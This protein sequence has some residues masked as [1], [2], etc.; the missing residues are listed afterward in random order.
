VTLKRGENIKYK[1]FAFSEHGILMLSSVLGSERA[2]AV[3][4]TIMRTFVKIRE[5]LASQKDLVHRLDELEQKYDK[6]FQV[7]FDAIR[8]LMTPSEKSKRSI[9]FRVGESKAIYHSRKP[10]SR[11]S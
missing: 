5:M 4:I 1:P 10:K 11:K 7:V 6:H 9:G 2:I 3:N 8:Q